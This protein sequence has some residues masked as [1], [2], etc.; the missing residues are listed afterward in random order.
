VFD[1][2]LYQVKSLFV[3]S[4]WFLLYLLIKDARSFAHKVIF[5]RR[6]VRLFIRFQAIIV[7]P[8][9]EKGDRRACTPLCGGRR[10]RKGERGI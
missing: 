7:L 5:S 3:A 2:Y 4:S 1:G 9:K 8:R 10:G 6:P